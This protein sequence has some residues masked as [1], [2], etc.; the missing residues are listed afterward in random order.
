M[1]MLS[2]FVVLNLPRASQFE[3]TLETGRELALYL[4]SVYHKGQQEGEQQTLTMDCDKCTIS[5][6]PSDGNLAQ[7]KC[8]KNIKLVS[9]TG[10]EG[11]ELSSG[12][13][14]ID[15]PMEGLTQSMQFV[16]AGLDLREVTVT[17]KLG[18]LLCEVD[19]KNVEQWADDVE[20][21]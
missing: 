18:G 12:I 7:W 13:G 2:A 3:T 19:D 9:V 11:F 6:T 17:W 8:P 4:K 15:I 20:R 21:F 14:S 1:A 10:V 16:L 5:L